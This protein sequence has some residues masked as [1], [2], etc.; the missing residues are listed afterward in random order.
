MADKVQLTL[1]SLVQDLDEL[2]KKGIF[3][4]K[5]VKKILKKED[6]MNI[7][8]K[9]LMFHHLIFLKQLNMKKF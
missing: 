1:E 6:N 4:K 9:K 5:D 3:Q 2:V 8:L 7:L